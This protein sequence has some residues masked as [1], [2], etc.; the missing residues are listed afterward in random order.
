MAAGSELSF[1]PSKVSG[2]RNG[3][4]PNAQLRGRCRALDEN[5]PLFYA[6][7]AWDEEKMSLKDRT[8]CALLQKMVAKRPSEET[9]PWMRE[10]LGAMG[11]K[12]DWVSGEYLTP[13][14][15]YMRG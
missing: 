3:R 11:Q 7:G 14:L 5:V 12:R 10:L 4:P 1:C 9:E 15:E 2:K 8:M 13:L 6:R